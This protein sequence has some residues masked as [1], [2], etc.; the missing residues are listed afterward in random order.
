LSKAATLARAADLWSSVRRDFEP[1][2]AL[3]DINV[4]ETDVADWDRV[5]RALS[6]TGWPA[7][8]FV[9]GKQLEVT[10]GFDVM[11]D[12]RQ[13]RHVLLAV[14]AD[15]IQLNCHFFESEKIEFDLDPGEV[16]A[17]TFP[18]LCRFMAMLSSVTGKTCLLSMENV[19]E[20]PLPPILS[21][22]A[23]LDKIIAH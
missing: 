21:V 9:G 8:A 23:G 1:D 4:L 2:G 6:E 18:T 3:R 5:L 16:D 22:D 20:V 17:K 13:E 14:S 7:K 12:H 11:F 10:P 15:G 19:A